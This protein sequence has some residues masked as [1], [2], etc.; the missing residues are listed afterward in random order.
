ME[1]QGLRDQAH[2]FEA[3]NCRIIG[4]SFDTP[5]DNSAFRTEFDFPFPLLCDSERS[6][7][8]AYE[9]KRP[10][11]D[12]R[13]G[14]PMRISYLIDP[15]GIIRRAYEVSDPAAHAAEVLADLGALHSG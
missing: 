4:A 15:E 3:L 5:A 7:G 14:Y 10:A 11:G 1:G 12:E 9:T 6:V 8:E 2:E 13:E